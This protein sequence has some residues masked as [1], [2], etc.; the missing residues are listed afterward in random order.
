MSVLDRRTDGRE[1]AYTGNRRQTRDVHVLLR[2]AQGRLSPLQVRISIDCL[3][4]HRLTLFV[5]T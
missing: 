1:R 4:T 3:C 2:D 5:F